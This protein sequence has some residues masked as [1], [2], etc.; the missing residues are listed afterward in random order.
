MDSGHAVSWIILSPLAIVTDV[1]A[2]VVIT[3]YFPFY[4][5]TDVTLI[6]VLTA[7]LGNAMFVVPVP[8]VRTLLGTPWSPA[9][10]QMYT[11]C[12]LTFRA[13]Q[14]SSLL[15]MSINW[16]TLLKLSAQKK[17]YVSTKYL[18]VTVVFVWLSAAVF[19][20]LPV[21]GVVQND[22]Y[23]YDT[24]K[25]LGFNLGLGFSLFFIVYIPLVLIVTLIS[26]CDAVWLI[27][28]MKKIVEVRD[29]A[30]RGI[31]P[32][33]N[34]S[35]P[36][37]V[38]GSQTGRRQ[39]LKFAWELS[40]FSLIFTI[41]SFLVNQIPYAM[42]QGT[43]LF[44]NTDRTA[45]E[46]VSIYLV[47]LEA[48]LAPHA[49]W[50]L[51][52]R[53]R[54][55]LSYQWN[56]YILRNKAIHEIEPEACVLQSYICREKDLASLLPSRPQS[57]AGRSMTGTIRSTKSEVIDRTHVNGNS[58][59]S[60]MDIFHLHTMT[61]VLTRD[62]NGKVSSD[63]HVERPL[64]IYDERPI[65]VGGLDLQLVDP[66]EYSSD[67]ER[68]RNSR[69]DL[70]KQD[71]RRSAS[72]ISRQNWRD[73]LRK[74]QLP[75]I[76]INKGFDTSDK[77]PVDNRSKA[78]I[79][80]RAA[81]ANRSANSNHFYMSSD[82]HPDYLTDS[83]PR[84]Q[85]A[86]TMSCESEPGEP[87]RFEDIEEVLNSDNEAGDAALAT[88]DQVTRNTQFTTFKGATLPNQNPGVR[89]MT[90]MYGTFHDLSCPMRDNEE[91]EFDNDVIAIDEIDKGRDTVAIKVPTNVRYDKQYQTLA[92]FKPDD[93]CEYIDGVK[94]H[95]NTFT[96]N[97]SF[98]RPFVSRYNTSGANATGDNCTISVTG[99]PSRSMTSAGYHPATSYGGDISVDD[100]NL[101]SG[102][103]AS[104]ASVTIQA[105][106]GE[107]RRRVWMDDYNEF[108]SDQGDLLMEDSTLQN[109]AGQVE[110]YDSKYPD[111]P[112]SELSTPVSSVFDDETD[113]GFE[114]ALDMHVNSSPLLYGTIGRFFESIEEEPEDLA[115][116]GG[117]NPFTSSTSGDDFRTL[118]V[119]S[120]NSNSRTSSVTSTH[121]NTNPFSETNS[122]EN[123]KI[124]TYHS[125]QNDQQIS[126]GVDFELG[127]S[128]FASGQK[129]EK[130]SRFSGQPDV[131][132][133]KANPWPSKSDSQQT[134]EDMAFESD[135]ISASHVGNRKGISVAVSD[136]TWKATHGQS[137]A[138]G[139]LTLNQTPHMSA[140]K[141]ASS[142]PVPM[143]VHS[144]DRPSPRPK[145][146][147]PMRGHS[148]E[149][150]PDVK[151]AFF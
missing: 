73:N 49:L 107:S 54:H 61:P 15:V 104:D 99:N 53:Y 151:P 135:F 2:I 45:M 30:E 47:A 14:V 110:K 124:A 77:S 82:Y 22:F 75:P 126:E 131:V 150:Q 92:S 55:A 44:S 7:M 5:G 136:S 10:C 18:K 101:S 3:H 88:S 17:R 23:S 36:L 138:G 140:A 24:C 90:H 121:S 96:D 25:F 50:L 74:K 37:H 76:F 109:S 116:S 144:L 148:F 125:Q 118:A 114:E 42:I 29:Q 58:R 93:N 119:V 87:Y 57:A 133:V 147:P 91:V 70:Q 94:G 8:A 27:K 132:P 105:Y 106:A 34:G 97:K 81:N 141:P 145:R 80:E 115:S 48:L 98:I 71:V 67:V 117:S 41:L 43:Q 64:S 137:A 146:H 26:S 143:R 83:L 11:W 59:R 51:C 19:G 9:L 31:L 16:S 60:Q 108:Q 89:E 100:E 128:G 129:R 122:H 95:N 12:A 40:H 4:H 66:R 62:S 134:S 123:T 56:A 120:R 13:A 86:K 20:L 78:G 102:S 39:R 46:V 103:N 63:V 52:Q 6:S 69:V 130:H 113:R 85:F 38:G 111:A 79:L 32:M 65:D 127:A 72:S 35:M 28:H 1:L 33:R 142:K 68:P 112:H 84:K 149:L 139:R 21:I